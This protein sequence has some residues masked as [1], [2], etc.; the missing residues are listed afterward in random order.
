MDDDEGPEEMYN[1]YSDLYIQA[2][3]AGYLSSLLAANWAKRAKA[4]DDKKKQ[5]MLETSQVFKNLSAEANEKA[6][7]AYEKYDDLREKYDFD[8]IMVCYILHPFNIFQQSASLLHN[9]LECQ[10]ICSYMDKFLLMRAG[11]TI[12]PGYGTLLRNPQA[13]GGDRRSSAGGCRSKCQEG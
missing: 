8:H 9:N 4:S 2:K 11:P 6:E 3:N 12:L 7:K 5:E 13:Q 1:A 10:L